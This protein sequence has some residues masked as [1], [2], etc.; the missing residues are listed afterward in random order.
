MS[1]IAEIFTAAKEGDH[2]K[3]FNEV[4]TKLKTDPER[5]A[6]LEALA[7]CFMKIEQNAVAYHLLKYVYSRIGPAP[8]TLNNLGMCAMG[9]ASSSGDDKFLNEAESLFKK[10]LGRIP[11]S[12]PKEVK[13]RLL[14]NLSLVTL[15][16]G[17]IKNAEKLS[18]EAAD[19]IP[20]ST[21]ANEHLA[22]A[23][24]S[25]GKWEEGF[26]RY[27]FALGTKYR[28]PKP[29]NKEPY[30]QGEPGTLFVRCEQGIG[31]T[32]T[33]ASVINDAKKHNKI[34]LECDERL[35]GLFKRSFPDIEVHATR[36]AEVAEWKEG[37]AFD[38]HCLIGSLCPFYRK[39]D[40]DFP[41][42]AFLKPDPERV[43]Q[44]RTLLGTKP[45]IKVGIAWRGG[46]SNTF[47]RRRSHKLESWL[48]LLKTPG[49]TWV[50]LDYKD[51]TAELE[52]LERKH[53]IKVLHY[54]RATENC[55]Y[56]ETAALVESLDCVVTTTTAIAHLCGA[57]GKECHVIVPRKTRWFYISDS[58]K[59]R[60]Y[61]SLTLWR[62]QDKWPIERIAQVLKGKVSGIGENECADNFPITSPAKS[63]ALA[64]QAA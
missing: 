27:E 60:W 50:S 12:A 23:L 29:V 31:D 14:E 2:A 44:W 26:Q 54:P 43:L 17:D 8:E 34:T 51:P 30:W 15:N 57:I 64:L 62:Q 45:G 61:D 16:Q 6:L 53:G 47:Q 63:D 46:L 37:R 5:L 18:R 25:Q 28:K 59:H 56:D 38:Y 10:A 7:F 40:S 52:E 1:D 58:E 42:T 20:D 32:I 3:A 36:F 9:I 33:Y 4:Y 19:V 13:A 49:I 35:G 39:N 48:Q 22:Y 11:K 55:D 24:L 21:G 41:R